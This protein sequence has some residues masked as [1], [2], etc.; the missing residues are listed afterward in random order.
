[1][2]FSAA[3]AAYGSQHIYGIARMCDIFAMDPTNPRKSEQIQSTHRRVVS[4]FAQTSFGKQLMEEAGGEIEQLF[5][6]LKN[7]G[8]EQPRCYGQKRYLLHVRLIFL[9]HNIAYLF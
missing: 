2:F 3:D 7:E 8:L 9:V 5:S 1:M 6:K 4:H